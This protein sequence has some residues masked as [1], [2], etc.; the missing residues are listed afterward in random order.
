MVSPSDDALVALAVQARTR[1]HAPYSHYAVGAAVLGASGRVFSGCNVEISSYSLTCCAERVAVF[2]AISEGETRLL[3]VAVVTEDDPPA[4]PCGACRQ[5]LYDFGGAELRVLVG[6]PGGGVAR[7]WTL[8]ELLP[9]A[10]G[11]DNLLGR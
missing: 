5:V 9:A 2:K 7:D 1:A 11:P 4:S 6:H 3:A 8:G 10:F